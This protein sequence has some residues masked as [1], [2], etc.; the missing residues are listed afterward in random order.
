MPKYEVLIN[1]QNFL[2]DVE[3]R[4]EKHGFFT[5]RFIEATDAAAAE[6]EAVEMIRKAEPLRELVRNTPEDPP[7]LD[8]TQIVELECLDGTEDQEPGFIWYRNRRSGGGS[9]GN[10]NLTADAVS[11][12]G[13]KMPLLG[14]HLSVAGGCY[15][16]VEAAARYGMDCVQIF[17]KNNNQWA[18]RPLTTDDAA[19]FRDALDEHAI[20]R[21]CGHASYLINLASPEPLLWQKSLDAFLIELERA[22]ALG[23]LGLVIH[24]GSYIDSS[25][26]QGLRQIVRALDQALART[27]GMQVEIWLETTAG[28]GSSLGHR[29]EHLQFLLDEVASNERLGVCIDSC[30]LFAAGYPL[31]SAA[32]YEDTME[33]FERTVGLDRVRAFHLNDSKRPLGSRVDRHEHIGEG[34][35]GI[36][37][38]RRILNDPRFADLPMYLETPKGQRDG[39]DLDAINLATLRR[40]ARV[41]ARP[42]KTRARSR[43]RLTPA[44]R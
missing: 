18:C 42:A 44:G 41:P 32:E 4:I 24:P 12:E 3:G 1:G 36:Q 14:A 37:P 29:F 23:L 2:V 33:Q 20:Q 11:V 26:E 5:V 16:A 34:Q 17:T 31:G 13:E 40:L 39:R 19:R 10:G 9:S 38:F 6:N 22:E 7:I 43:A 25:E 30:H 21:P 15:K 35:L 8:V 27:D 28:Q